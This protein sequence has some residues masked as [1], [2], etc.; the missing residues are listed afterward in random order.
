MLHRNQTLL[1]LVVNHEAIVDEQVCATLHWSLLCLDGNI[2]A[3]WFSD[4]SLTELID[5]L[6]ATGD[7][8]P[9][10]DGPQ[11]SRGE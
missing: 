3:L 8:L 4:A 7:P 2:A 11:A 1:P 9:A 10:H 6:Q 5:S